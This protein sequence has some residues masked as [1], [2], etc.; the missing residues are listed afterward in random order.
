[1]LT[2][3]GGI[4]LAFFVLMFLPEVIRGLVALLLFGGAALMLLFTL[5]LR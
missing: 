3:A 4:I 2:I 5:L 1:M